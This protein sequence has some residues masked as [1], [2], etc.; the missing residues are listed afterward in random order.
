M[1]TA[2][3]PAVTPADRL[4][5][6]YLGD[7]QASNCCSLIGVWARFNVLNHEGPDRKLAAALMP[8]KLEASTQHRYGFT[9]QA[10]CGKPY[11]PYTGKFRITKATRIPVLFPTVPVDAPTGLSRM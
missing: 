5:G 4:N 7:F 9:I 8:R 3:V 11:A 10:G 2:E 6:R 1:A